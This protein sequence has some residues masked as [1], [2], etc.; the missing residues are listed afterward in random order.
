MRYERMLIAAV[1]AI[2]AGAV[3][4]AFLT[5]ALDASDSV[6]WDQFAQL[7]G[8]WRQ[9]LT[10]GLLASSALSLCMSLLMSALVKIHVPNMEQYMWVYLRVQWLARRLLYVA[11][12]FG[13]TFFAFQLL[14][15]VLP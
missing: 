5:S 15:S 8:A 7:G 9:T 10:L 4:I 6:A 11:A 14:A 13:V 2:I 3:G 12:G 1:A